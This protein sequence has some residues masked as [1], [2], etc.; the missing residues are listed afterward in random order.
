MRSSTLESLDES[1]F[2]LLTGELL[3]TLNSQGKVIVGQYSA[4]QTCRIVAANC[5]QCHC[6]SDI[7]IQVNAL[8]L[9][10]EYLN[11]NNNLI[12]LDLIQINHIFTHSVDLTTNHH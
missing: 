6:M 8:N 7:N 12:T 3:I 4:L 10:I 1:N 11:H 2:A 9:K 5:L